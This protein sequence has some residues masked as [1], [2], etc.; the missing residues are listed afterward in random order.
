MKELKKFYIIF[1][2]QYRVR[3]EWFQLTDV[4]KQFI[5]ML[6]DYG[7]TFTDPNKVPVNNFKDNNEVVVDKRLKNLVC[8]LIKEYEDY[9]GVEGK[10]VSLSMVVKKV[11]EI[12]GMDYDDVENLIKQLK[13]KG[14]I[15]EPQKGRIKCA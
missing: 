2:E 5:L 8:D 15:Y 4:L 10:A 12:E 3:G 11:A 7:F 13:R 14:I 1:F 6:K 9:Y